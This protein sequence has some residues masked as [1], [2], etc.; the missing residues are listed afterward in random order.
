MTSHDTQEPEE[1]TTHHAL[2]RA[3]AVLFAI[4]M[5]LA[6][7][8]AWHVWHRHQEGM[9]MGSTKSGVIGPVEF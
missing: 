6:L 1:E 7:M 5:L 8:T 9:L 2:L 4:L 3:V